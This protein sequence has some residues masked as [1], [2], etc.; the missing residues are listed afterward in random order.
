MNTVQL[1]KHVAEYILGQAQ[2]LV[3]DGWGEELEDGTQGPGII[4]ELGGETNAY[5]FLNSSLHLIRF[6]AGI[7]LESVREANLR[8]DI[9]LLTNNGVDDF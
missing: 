1:T 4:D 6:V 9:S 2:L 3:R 7:L 8:D 5:H